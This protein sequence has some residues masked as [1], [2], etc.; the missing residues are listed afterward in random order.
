MEDHRKQ[1]AVFYFPY[2]S[3]SGTILYRC[4]LKKGT[5]VKPYVNHIGL[6]YY[7]NYKQELLFNYQIDLNKSV[8][9]LGGRTVEKDIQFP[10]LQFLKD[11]WNNQYQVEVTDV[12]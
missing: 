11:I 5:T 9:L 8:E 2:Y 6:H 7:L 1:Q 10:K 4:W 12:T 3:L